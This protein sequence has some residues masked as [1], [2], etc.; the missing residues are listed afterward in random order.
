[1]L[2]KKDVDRILTWMLRSND[3]V[4]DLI[5][6]P[7][8]PLQVESSGKLVKVATD[9]AIEN[10]TPYQTEMLT[11]GI[12]GNDR[13]NY[14]ALV[15]QGSADCAYQLGE[16]C[17]FRVN[18]FQQ[19]KQYAMVLRKLETHIQTLADLGLPAIF[20]DM[21]QEK[22][23]LILVTGST[24]SGKSTTLA[25]LL[26]EMNE[27]RP[28]HILTIEDPIEYVHPHK[29]ATFNQRELGTDF[30]TF[31]SSLRAALRQAPKVILIGE[32]RDRATVEIGLAAAST[33]HLVLSTLHSI[34]CGQTIN[35]IVGMFDK[36]EEEQIRAKLAECL[37]YVVSQRLLPRQPKGRIPSQEI[38]GMNLR[39]KEIVLAGESEG[40]TYYDIISVS[41]NRGW[42]THDQ[43]IAGMYAAGHVSEET[44]LAYA[45]QKAVL[46][47]LIDRIKQ[48]RG[49][50]EDNGLNLSIDTSGKEM[51]NLIKKAWPSSPQTW[52][53]RFDLPENHFL[54]AYEPLLT[55]SEGNQF[56]LTV[57]LK[58]QGVV[59]G[60]NIA[61]PG[62]E[63]QLTASSSG[64]A[65]PI[66]AYDGWKIRA[67]TLGPL[68]LTTKQENMLRQLIETKLPP[69]IEL[70][71]PKFIPPKQEA[72]KV[73]A[74][75]GKLFHVNTLRGLSEKATDESEKAAIAQTIAKI[76][77]RGL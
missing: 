33:G 45:S 67:M 5:F 22:N 74:E 58:V 77:E 59:A 32:M 73:L 40:K 72:L 69:Q 20:K 9:P 30:D 21:A 48:E 46:M 8:R 42:Q 29:M 6:T 24:G 51:E 49:V 76:Q 61:N 57:G 15:K 55:N 2:K 1:M 11:V 52:P 25:G 50:E 71:N 16:D 60:I 36:E 3:G 37:R 41:G 65:N 18:A 43:A 23:G 70:P 19:R 75:R 31:A 4:S 27:T 35:R 10:L 26:N 68:P 14:Q 63:M 39:V 56:F 17:R 47:R 34:D 12:L 66:V 54:V 44:A 38:M 13:G 53:L 28:I 7:G 64:G 62:G